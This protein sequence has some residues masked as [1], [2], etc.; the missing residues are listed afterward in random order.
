MFPE[1]ECFTVLLVLGKKEIEVY[2]D[3]LDEFGQYFK[4]VYESAP[5]FHDGRWLWI[6]VNSI[7][8][9]S[10]IEKMI[11]IKKKPAKAKTVL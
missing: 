4:A 2:R 9:I 3:R 5:Q 8:D 1:K 10:D 11:R 6:K 7:D